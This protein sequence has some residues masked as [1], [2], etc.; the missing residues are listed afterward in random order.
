MKKSFYFFG[1]I[2][3]I[4]AVAPAW[5]QLNG[6]YTIG[7][8]SPTFSTI[9]DACDSLV[10]VGVS[11]PVIMN[12]RDGIYNEHVNLSVVNGVSSTNTITFQSETTDSANVYIVGNSNNTFYTQADFLRFR[13]L[14][15]INLGG[16]SALYLEEGTNYQVTGCALKNVL[17]SSY[18]I[19]CYNY[20]SSLNAFTIQNSN[21]AGY[22]GLNIDGENINNV[23]IQ[24]TK[25]IGSYSGLQIYG[26][27][28][29]NKIFIN[30]S[31]INGATNRGVFIQGG[32]SAKNIRVQNSNIKSRYEQ[33]YI[34]ALTNVDSLDIQ[35]NDLKGQWPVYDY[36]GINI[37][38]SYQN[39]TN[40]LI[41]NNSI[42]SVEN[43]C[44]YLYADDKIENIQLHNNSLHPQGDFSYGINLYANN[45]SVSNVDM[46]DNTIIGNL[47][48][49]SNGV[50]LYSYYFNL[51]NISM[52][53]DSIVVYGEPAYLYGEVEVK[54]VTID[55]VYMSGDFFNS[56][57]VLEIQ[58][59]DGTV[60]NIDIMNSTFEGQ[61]GVYV[62]GSI[63]VDN[64]MIDNCDILAYYD[65]VYAE[66]Y[67]SGLNHV[68]VKNSDIESW[69]DEGIYLEAEGYIE[70]VTIDNCTIDTY[71]ESI[72]CN[73]YTDLKNVIITNSDI[74]SEDDD[75][76]YLYNYVG[77]SDSLKID[78]CTIT[79]YDRGIYV[80]QDYGDLNNLWITN[81]HIESEDDESIET[82]CDG[83]SNGLIVE[84]NIL[85]S[86]DGNY[87]Y[88]YGGINNGK[89]NNNTIRLNYEWN[90]A[91]YVY[92]AGSNFEIK[93]NTIDTTDGASFIYSGIYVY[94]Y[95]VPG[96]ASIDIDSN[97]I[98]N[99]YEY[100]IYSG[101]GE[102]LNIRG[103]VLR[104]ELS[105]NDADGIYINYQRDGYLNIINN[106]IL[107]DDEDY[108]IYGDY[109]SVSLPNK[110]LIANNFI[111]GFDYALYFDD[112]PNVDIVYNSITTNENNNELI[113]LNYNTNGASIVNNIFKVDSLNYSNYTLIYV[114][115]LTQM[116]QIRNNIVNIDT[117]AT[118]FVYDNWYGN[119]YNSIYELTS[120][121]G[122][123]VG[124][125]YKTVNFVNDTTDLHVA[126]NDNSLIA[127]FN[128]P[129]VTSDID[130]NNRAVIPT[131]GADEI[132][133]SNNIFANDPQFICA[134]PVVLDAGSSPN[135]TFSWNTGAT[136][137]SITVNN[138]G[139]YSVTITTPCG[140][141]TDNVT[142]Q[143]QNPTTAN[144]TSA[145]SFLT[146][147]FNNTSTNATSYF[148]NFG[149]SNTSTDE[150]PVHIYAA[151]G[152]YN[153]TLIAYGECTSDTI[154]FQVT[155]STGAGIEEATEYHFN[156]YPNPTDGAFTISM[157]NLSAEKLE[158]MIINIQGQQ[159]YTY[160]A[161]QVYGALNLPMDISNFPS[162]IYIIRVMADQKSFSARM[163]KK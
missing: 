32:N 3:L 50:Y 7:G 160:Q 25:V 52:N 158:I 43:N 55:N 6:T 36:D 45:S 150:D 26:D 92:G 75:G 95:Y 2:T 99:Y 123:G 115:N 85:T 28:Y 63:L 64:L 61:Y 57:D 86:Y 155:V 71:G 111:T 62:Y 125:F 112:F 108:G 154:T 118:S 18:G 13:D 48:K 27:Q 46:M 159:V 129:Q 113:Y 56:D 69:D 97:Y 38:S 110:P 76:I 59:G 161:E 127:G 163:I 132:L 84:N 135:S 19:Y 148:W 44:I 37:Y 94:N 162:G 47:S 39:I 65:A 128:F 10:S 16:F 87:F 133:S 98:H 126:C 119:Y 143:Y 81:N 78:S 33:L 30:N 142:V 157:D 80:Y 15:F 82:D 146:T 91:L 60:R 101:Y 151:S 21:L 147:T 104:N 51:E 149:D 139:T 138:P 79:T 58:A 41:N 140:A 134:D 40:A 9:Q 145:V 105:N 136:T 66:G 152:T 74:D 83:S 90:E 17:N 5:G 121:T 34:I 31:E 117:T 11:G 67:Y 23:S 14:T 72:Y 54:N 73:A 49:Y 116:N 130:G 12:I 88:T 70:N 1:F 24:N 107:S 153:V 42:D 89:I 96:G 144:A 156:A 68:T 35:N 120:Q 4:L 77:V 109:S 141:I 103:N 8:T 20:T 106:Q 93:H 53:G 114:D 124:S 137:Q 102:N 122:F 131:I 22:S 29:L 100:G